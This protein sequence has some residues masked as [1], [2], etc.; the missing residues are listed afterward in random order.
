MDTL[1]EKLSELGAAELWPVTMTRSVVPARETSTARH[2]H[3]RR[4]AIEAARQSGRAT[5]LQ[6]REGQSLRGAVAA[7]RSRSLRLVASLS[8]EPRPLAEVVSRRPPGD[9][10]IFIGPEGDFDPGELHELVDGG[11]VPAS[12]G[13]TVL[14]VETAAIVAVAAVVL[15]ADA[16]RARSAGTPSSTEPEETHPGHKGEGKEERPCPRG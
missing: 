12:L 2:G 16:A 5:V 4:L 14:R 9:T 11:V 3:W 10:A 6:I 8:G 1:V 15:W 13:P 7:L